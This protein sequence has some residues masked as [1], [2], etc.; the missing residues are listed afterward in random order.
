MAME[1]ARELKKLFIGF[2]V[3]MSLV[4]LLLVVV[5]FAVGEFRFFYD[6]RI[7]QLFICDGPNA[8]TDLP[9]PPIATFSA[10]EKQLYVCGYLQTSSPVRL[11][12]LLFYEDRSVGWFALDR[13]HGQGY[14]FEP[15]PYDRDHQPKPG[16]HR[17][18]VYRARSKLG[19]TEFIVTEP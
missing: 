16:I 18:D 19:S 5:L 11:D 13:K 2:V 14:F 8:T 4:G 6:A 15:L 7:T 10:D 9:M 17:V 1:Q 3:T 12:F